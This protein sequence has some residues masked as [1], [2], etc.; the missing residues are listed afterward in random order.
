MSG[1]RGGAIPDG[2]RMRGMALA[3]AAAVLST[4]A[5]S[6]TAWSGAEG[7]AQAARAAMLERARA[8]SQ[9][10]ARRVLGALDAAAGKTFAALVTASPDALSSLWSARRDFPD[11]VVA[12]ILVDDRGRRLYPRPPS[13]PAP[14]WVED[15]PEDTEAR[16]ILRE[17]WAAEFERRDAAAAVSLYEAAADPR[18]GRSVRIEALANLGAL[19]ARRGEAAAASVAFAALLDP[20]EFPDPFVGAER[21]VQARLGLAETLAGSGRAGEAVAVLATLEEELEAGAGL[22]TA[23]VRHFSVGALAAA[24]MAAA[25]LAEASPERAALAGMRERWVRRR[26]EPAVRVEPGV[27]DRLA[28]AAA[29]ALAAGAGTDVRWSVARIGRGDVLLAVRRLA[30]RDRTYAA[31]VEWA[32]HGWRPAVE[33]ALAQ[34]V[35]TDVRL[36]LCDGAGRALG[37]P[38]AAREND[39]IAPGPGAGST[40]AALAPLGEIPGWAVRADLRDPGALERTLAR[41]RA[42]VAGAAALFL[43]VTL[44][45]LAVLVRTARREMEL[46]ALKGEF[47]SH[48]SHE[49]KTPLSV[50]RM[51]AETLALGR[52]RDEAQRR[53]FLETIARESERLT[54]MIDNVLD[55]SRIEQGRRA[56]R[57]EAVDLRAILEEAVAVRRARLEQEGFAL[58]LDLPPLPILAGDDEAL[59]SVFGNLLDNAARYSSEVKT[60]SVAA[61]SDGG[62]I[63]V[64]VADRGIGVDPAERER[65]FEPFA[66]GSDER[67][68]RTKG[69]GL[70]LA[71]VR[72]A[73]HAHGGRV[74][75]APNGGQGSIFSV[76]LPCQSGRPA[77][78]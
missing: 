15:R 7:S 8:E 19:R 62:G 10:G 27:E 41:S 4:L 61:R 56:Y 2:R 54:G 48:V 16:R 69:T 9:A 72:H 68:R 51:F 42:A 43:C 75:V 47:V 44:A 77:A 25:A 12:L 29:A 30:T 58:A 6:W 32:D 53:E 5:L 64:D 1:E 13:A 63:T 76:R 55:F 21:R 66:R 71:L 34:D 33:A 37:A 3:G 59:A 26:D 45:G 20:A 22:P 11:G 78:S 65:I 60:I 74:T 49:L 14:T 46:A 36:R 50:I 17:A 31:A 67:A 28:A 18:F 23:A 52:T 73:V 24:E 57:F 39:G 38:A 35:G 70:G 40:P